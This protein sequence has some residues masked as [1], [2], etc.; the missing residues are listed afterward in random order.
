LRVPSG[1]DLVQ[2]AAIPEVFMTAYDALF[3]Q[4]GLKMGEQVLIH[5]VGSGVGTA[6]LQLARATGATPIGTS[7][8]KDKLARVRE[9]GLEHGIVPDDK[10]FADQVKAET[11]GRMA[12][13]I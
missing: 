4:A 3:L 2:A 7:R 5:A 11:K 8:S 13:V 9:L 6:A 12:D 1:I 10:G